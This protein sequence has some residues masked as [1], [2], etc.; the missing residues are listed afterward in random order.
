MSLG[1]FNSI[2]EVEYVVDAIKKSVID[3]RKIM[4]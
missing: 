3:I 4:M 1:Y 2:D